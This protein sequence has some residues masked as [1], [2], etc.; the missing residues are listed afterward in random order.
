[1]S[2]RQSVPWVLACAVAETVGMAASAGAARA[3]SSTGVVTGFLFILAGG[4]VEGTGLGLLQATVLRDRLGGRRTPWLLV[5]VLVAGVGWA[6]GSAPAALSGDDSGSPPPLGSVLLGAAAMGLVMGA[7]LGAAQAGAL[8]GHAR[9]PWRWCAANACGWAVAMPV[10]FLGATTAGAGWPWLLVVG[11]GALTGAVA[12]TAL[13][14]VT[15]AWLPSLDGAPV[16]HR[17]IL[18]Y[19]TLRRAE[20]VAG[21]AALTVTGRRTGRRFTFPVMTAPLGHTELLVLP[22]HPDRK[23]WWRNVDPAWVVSVLDRG[24]WTTAKARLLRSGSPG[25]AVARSA[26]LARWPRAQI[27]TGL[28]VVLDLRPAEAAD[29]RDQ[30]PVS[31]GPAAVGATPTPS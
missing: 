1:M 31:R 23:T 30:G 14:A 8:R 3:A 13:G 5:T 22:G 27:G 25:Y 15:G 26:Y 4:L 10:V 2:R 7:V 19:L 18:G 6:A 21:W 20:A 17:A 11:Y 28:L 24:S 9:H 12:G 16:L 29:L